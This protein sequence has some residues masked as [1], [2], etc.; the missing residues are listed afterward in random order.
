MAECIDLR[1][2]EGRYKV[3]PGG[4]HL[5]GTRLDIWN[6][7][8]PCKYGKI[9]PHGGTRLQAY[10]NASLH[11]RLALKALPCVTVHQQGDFEIT[12]IFEV[13]DLPAVAEV[14]KPRVKPPARDAPH[15]K[16]FRF[17]KKG[18]KTTLESTIDP[19]AAQPATDQK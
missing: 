16:A 9:Y 13:G 5:P 18:L 11:R 10:C 4:D 12:V 2:L 14:L 17:V 6:L 1:T 3:V 19:Q 7:E 15:L 8:I